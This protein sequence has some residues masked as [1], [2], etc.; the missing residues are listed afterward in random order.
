MTND[1][2]N[3]LKKIS[4]KTSFDDIKQGIDS[5]ADTVA[6]SLIVSIKNLKL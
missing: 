2:V 6:N 5:L 3:N 4:T 1:M